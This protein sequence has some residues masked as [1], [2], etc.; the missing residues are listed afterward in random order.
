MRRMI[1]PGVWQDEGPGAAL[2]RS[3]RQQAVTGCRLVGQMLPDARTEGPSL[4][5][6][7]RA[8][9]PAIKERQRRR[10]NGGMQG[11]RGAP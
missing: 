2:G 5:W 11:D 1:A 3:S 10:W 8:N 4:G 9:D 6:A 7:K